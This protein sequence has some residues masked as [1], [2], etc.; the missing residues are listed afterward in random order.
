MGAKQYS[1]I[2]ENLFYSGAPITHSSMIS[3]TNSTPSVVGIH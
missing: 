3:I 2:T 1:L